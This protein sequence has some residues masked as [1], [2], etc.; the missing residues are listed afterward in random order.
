VRQFNSVDSALDYLAERT[1]LARVSIEQAS[2]DKQ[3]ARRGEHRIRYEQAREGLILANRVKYRYIGVVDDQRRFVAVKKIIEKGG[4]LE[5]FYA[6]FQFRPPN[7]LPLF[8]F[9]IFDREEVVTRAPYDT[10]EDPIYLS[11]RSVEVASLFH[12]YFEKLWSSCRKI[13]R[14]EEIDSMLEVVRNDVE[15]S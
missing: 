8:S 1:S 11:I 9:T 6:A 2:L 3:R 4:L 12:G 14:V 10:G 5:N 15:G 13:D 7:G